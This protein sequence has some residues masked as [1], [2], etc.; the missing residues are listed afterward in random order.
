MKTDRIQ[1]INRFACDSA[2]AGIGSLQ[3]EEELHRSYCRS[4]GRPLCS[5][6]IESRYS[7]GHKRHENMKRSEETRAAQALNQLR[8]MIMNKITLLV[9]KFIGIDLINKIVS[10]LYCLEVTLNHAE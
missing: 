8:E 5:G 7:G 6:R 3:A 1:W 9:N 4:A 2:P 10:Q